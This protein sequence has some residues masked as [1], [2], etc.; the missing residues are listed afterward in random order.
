MASQNDAS[1]VD[2]KKI[3]AE[4]VQHIAKLSRLGIS[5]E[6]ADRYAKQMNSVMDYMEILNEVNTDGVEMT[7][8]VTGLQSVTRPDV[9]EVDADPSALLNAST[10]PKV[11]GQIAVRAVLKEE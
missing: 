9:I 11:G 8:Q 5:S 7:L 3:D 4:K 10:L 1:S 2:A 6:E